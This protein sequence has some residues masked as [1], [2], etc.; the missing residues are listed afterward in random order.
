[1]LSPPLQI[2]KSLNIVNQKVR[3]KSSVKL[4]GWAELCGRWRVSVCVLLQKAAGSSSRTR[5]FYGEGS[6]RMVDNNTEYSD[7]INVTLDQ[8]GSQLII[9]DVQLTDE[10]EFFC[11]VNGLAAGNAEGKTHLRVFGEEEKSFQGK[12]KLLKIP[13]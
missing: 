13:L 4:W 5:I 3:I 7:R 6:E 10:R 1:M 12:F 11:Q 8:H 2:N 9:K